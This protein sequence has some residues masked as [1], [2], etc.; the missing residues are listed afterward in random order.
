M[1]ALPAFLLGAT[2]SAA[3]ALVAC[4]SRSGPAAGSSDTSSGT[5][6]ADL[7][8]ADDASRFAY[9]V[10]FT[11]GQNAVAGLRADGLGA[12]PALVSK[13]FADGAAGRTPALP[14]AEFD[15]VLRAVHRTLLDRAA[16]AAYQRDPA[17]RALADENAA[18][19]AAALRTFAAQPGVQP[20]ADGVLVEVV[21]AGSGSIAPASVLRT[22]DWTIRRADG[23]LIDER[24]GLTVDPSALLPV[25]TEVV[26]AMR[27]G[28]R[29]RVAFAP[30]RAF[31]LGG[32]SPAIGP[33]EAL[34]V[35]VTILSLATQG[36]AR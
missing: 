14:E 1:H 23:T 2:A 16:L 27:V 4:S 30:E 21:Q 35:D 3:V 36:G 34:F 8:A 10:G 18:R 15:R 9:G 12:D 6:N 26:T 7:I 20:F 28:D 5:A 17:F 29:W 24:R 32:D 13:G 31:G 19:S 25:G 11:L 33:N 22:A